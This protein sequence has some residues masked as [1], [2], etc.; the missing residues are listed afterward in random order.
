MPIAKKEFILNYATNRWQ[1]N[2]KR[3]VGTTSDSIRLC[4]PS[5]IDEWSD[6]YYSNRRNYNHIDQLVYNF[7]NIFLAICQISEDFIQT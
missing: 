6:Y 5:S 1:L 2:F 7:I 4:N 3:N